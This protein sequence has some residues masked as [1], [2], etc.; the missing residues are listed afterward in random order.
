MEKIVRTIMSW[1]PACIVM[2]TIFLLS[3]RQNVSVSH[4]YWPNFAV[5]KT[6]HAVGYGILTLSYMW[7]LTTTTSLSFSSRCRLAVFLAVCYAVTDELHQTFVPTRTGSV[8][9]IGI[10]L[11]GMISVYW[12]L[13]FFY[14]KKKSIT[15]AS[16]LRSRTTQ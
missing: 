8:R 15:S 10:D 9:D 1:I 11:I 5:L 4:Q 12:I 3:S 2:I 14:G 6:I 16:S 13:Q 7:G